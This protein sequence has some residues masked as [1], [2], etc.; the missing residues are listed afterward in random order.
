VNLR[1]EKKNSFKRQT[2]SSFSSWKCLITVKLFYSE[3]NIF[4]IDQ[5]NITFAV[6]DTHFEQI[7]QFQITNTFKKLEK[8]NYSGFSCHFRGFPPFYVNCLTADMWKEWLF[9]R[10]SLTN[11]KPAKEI[12]RKPSHPEGKEK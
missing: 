5:Y 2:K 12:R 7:K 1:K 8:S 10:L 4:Y 6:T 3:I 11:R 9:C